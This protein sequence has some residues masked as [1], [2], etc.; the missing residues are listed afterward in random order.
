MPR[1]ASVGTSAKLVFIRLMNVTRVSVGTNVLAP[2]C[3]PS[4]FLFDAV[5]DLSKMFFSEIWTGSIKFNCLPVHALS[6]GLSQTRR[7]PARLIF[8]IILVSHHHILHMLFVFF[9]IQKNTT[10]LL[11]LENPSQKIL[12]GCNSRMPLSCPPTP[13]DCQSCAMVAWT[14]VDSSASF[15]TVYISQSWGRRMVHPG[16]MI[17]S[18]WTRVADARMAD[19]NQR[20]PAPRRHSQVTNHVLSDLLSNGIILGST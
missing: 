14:I 7:A 2:A 20:E 17:A 19:L 9:L 6:I 3:A 1:W 12:T 18:T 8:V 15:V 4:Q 13:L 11:S 16:K 5:D 10:N